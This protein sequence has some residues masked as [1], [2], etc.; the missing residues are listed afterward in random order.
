LDVAA[1]ETNE[2]NSATVRMPQTAMIV[3]MAYSPNDAPSRPQTFLA[4][5]GVGGGG[6]EEELLCLSLTSISP[7]FFIRLETI[8]LDYL[9]K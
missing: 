6:D 9:R 8:V 2:P 4:D 5:G 1:R 3:R 7:S